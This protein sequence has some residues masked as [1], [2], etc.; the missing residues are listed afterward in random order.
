MYSFMLS[1]DIVLCMNEVEAR[2]PRELV[3]REFFKATER[4][5]Q[6]PLGAVDAACVALKHMDWREFATAPLN[7]ARARALAQATGNVHKTKGVA[8]TPS[9]ASI[10]FAWELVRS[11]LV[12][13]TSMLAAS[14]S[15]GGVKLDTITQLRPD[16]LRVSTDFMANPTSRTFMAGVFKTASGVLVQPNVVA[17]VAEYKSG[18]VQ[19]AAHFAG[20]EPGNPDRDRQMDDQRRA[21]SDDV[22]GEMKVALEQHADLGAVAAEV[23]AHNLT[24]W[25]PSP[26]LVKAYFGTPPAS[27]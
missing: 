17:R 20:A 8:T 4:V 21:L 12:S 25:E 22:R 16:E 1:F 6:V 23:T 26:S 14:D 3:L 7:E 15:L 9:V 27:A 5:P 24:R 18:I 10:R 19:I 2:Q 11:T 13:A